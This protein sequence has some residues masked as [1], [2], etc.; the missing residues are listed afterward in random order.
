MLIN[1]SQ[2][3]S[4]PN[5][6]LSSPLP[7]TYSKSPPQLICTGKMFSLSCA[8]PILIIYNVFSNFSMYELLKLIGHS[9]YIF[10]KIFWFFIKKNKVL[11]MGITCSFLSLTLQ[12]DP[13]YSLL[14]SQYL[15]EGWEYHKNVR[16]YNINANCWPG[17][18]VSI[19]ECRNQYTHFKIF[20]LSF[21]D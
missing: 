13:C 6:I 18:T 10:L 20:A 19:S 9:I 11:K 16:D 15:V 1:F 8:F 3:L 17:V 5:A 4:K 12:D 7:L 14:S 2:N 21:K